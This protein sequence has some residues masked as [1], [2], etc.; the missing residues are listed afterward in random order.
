MRGIPVVA[1]INSAELLDAGA[2]AREAHDVPVDG[3][4]LPTGIVWLTE[5]RHACGAGS[6]SC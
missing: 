3:V 5:G 6:A 2:I 4:M 1:M